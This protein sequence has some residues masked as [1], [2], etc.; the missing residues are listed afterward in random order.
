MVASFGH[1]DGL[2]LVVVDDDSSVDEDGP[3]VG[4]TPAQR[5][6]WDR[7]S[8]A[9]MMWSGRVEDY[10]VSEKIL[11]NMTRF[12]MVT[13]SSGGAPPPNSDGPVARSCRIGVMRKAD[14]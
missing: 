5:D 9:Q 12:P 7:M 2:H 8:A 14:K 11:P 13:R 4:G 6:R 10:E 1:V 3:Y